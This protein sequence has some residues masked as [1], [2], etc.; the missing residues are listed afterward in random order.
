LARIRISLVSGNC[1][2]PGPSDNHRKDRIKILLQIAVPSQIPTEEIT[3]KKISTVIGVML[4]VAGASGVAM[5]VPVSAPEIDPGTA[6]SAIALV[7]GM[8]LLARARR[9]K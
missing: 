9:S 5:A 8:L 4:L 3:M 2:L 6:G 1:I 7:S